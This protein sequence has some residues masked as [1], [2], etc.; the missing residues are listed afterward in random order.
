MGVLGGVGFALAK[1]VQGRRNGQPRLPS[2]EE[3]AVPKRSET[4][5]I[6]PKMLHNVNLKPP[7]EALADVGAPPGPR[8]I[9]AQAPSGA[10]PSVSA[11]QPDARR[12]PAAEPPTAESPAPAAPVQAKAPAA[13]TAAPAPAAAAGPKL[14]VDPDGAICP[15]THPVKAKLASGIFHLPGMTAY[16]RTTPDRCY[17]DAAAAEADG[18]RK[19][20]R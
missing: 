13:A 1:L 4:P 5:L 17:P 16:D 2:G 11:P 14:W 19:A 15:S 7:S 8:L 12:A 20:K 6:D 10:R 18:L 9:G 3:P